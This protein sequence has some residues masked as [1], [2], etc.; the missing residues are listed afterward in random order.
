MRV[1][2][3]AKHAICY[4]SRSPFSQRGQ[5]VVVWIEDEIRLR[6]PIHNLESIV[7]MG[8]TGAS[9]ALM[10]L[11]AE[12]GVA[13]AFHTPNGRLMARLT[14]PTRATFCSEN[15]NTRCMTI[16]KKPLL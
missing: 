14:L 11:C 4:V 9:P 1:A 3:T 15:A 2:K 10:Q 8:Y 7:T 6:V 12:R 5:N 13:L 16:P